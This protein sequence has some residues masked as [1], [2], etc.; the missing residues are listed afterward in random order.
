MIIFGIFLLRGRLGYGFDKNVTRVCK[1]CYIH[2]DVNRRSA[3]VK[4]PLCKHININNSYRLKNS[5]HYPAKNLHSKDVTCIRNLESKD[6]N[7][8]CKLCYEFGPFLLRL[9]R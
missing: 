1:K 7:Y 5:H 6:V 8:N 2:A 9:V 4:N 3:C